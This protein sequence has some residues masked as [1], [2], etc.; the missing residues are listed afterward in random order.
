MKIMLVAGARPNFMKIAS[1]IDAIHGHNRSVARPVDYVLVHTGQHYDAQMSR[2][3]F[4]DLELPTPDIDLEVGSSSHANQTAEIMKRFEPVLLRER[5]HVVVVVGDVNSTLACALVAS[6]ISYPG[7]D[8]ASLPS[9][10]LVAHVEAGLRSFDR[11]MPEEINRMLT[12]S[13]SDFL[14]ITEESAKENLL[15]EGIPRKRIHFVGNTMV[16]TLLRHRQH[17]QASNILL[18]LGLTTRAG[19]HQPAAGICPIPPLKR[20]EVGCREYAVVT[21]HRPSNVDDQAALREIVEALSVIAKELP[22]L[23]PVHPRTLHRIKEFHL[24]KHLHFVPQGIEMEIRNSGI[25][26]LEPLGYLDFLCL[27][28][29]ARVV[30]TDS[31]GI[32]EETTVLGIPCVTLRQNTERPVTITDG[33][34]ALAGTKREAILRH[35]RRA[36]AGHAQPKRPKFWDGHA[37]ER[38]ISILSRHLHGRR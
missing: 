6:K 27:M 14:F 13:L 33:T 4:K 28:S 38:I 12:D 8:H 16:D 3:F 31:G 30:L 18:R 37:G 36:L 25:Y 22:I 10:P 9:R 29:N 19:S 24:E 11:S 20:Q 21:L 5:P 35:T 23:F 17:A 34:N 1:L 15:R 2:A 26:G 7:A 32:Q